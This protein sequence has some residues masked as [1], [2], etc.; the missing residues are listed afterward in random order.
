MDAPAN[1]PRPPRG[2][3]AKSKGSLAPK[4]VT[5]NAQMANKKEME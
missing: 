3:E 1:T 2:E 5:S 4:E